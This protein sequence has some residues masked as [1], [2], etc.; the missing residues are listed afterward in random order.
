MESIEALIRLGKSQLENGSFDEA[1]KSFEQAISFDQ[2]NPDLWNFMGATLRSLGRYDEAI[3][4]FIKSLKI[5][6]RDKDSS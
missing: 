1:L 3:D 4:C 2:N 5:V 6:P